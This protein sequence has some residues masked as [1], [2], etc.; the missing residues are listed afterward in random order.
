MPRFRSR[1]VFGIAST[2]AT[3][4]IA[5]GCS[6]ARADAALIGGNSKTPCVYSA[7]SIATLNAFS[8]MVGRQINCATVY[9]NASITWQQWETPWF[10]NYYNPDSDWSQWA[11]TPGTNRQLVIT[12][13]LIPSSLEG[14]DWLDAGAAGDYTTYAKTLAQNLVN[15]GLGD[16]IIRLSPEANGT[17]YSDSLGTT[18]TQWALWDQFWRQTVLAMRSVPGA[19]FQFDWCIAALYRALPLSE[20][21][22]GSDVVNIIGIDAYDTGNI[23]TTAAARW[24][25][26]LNGSDGIQAVLNFAAAQGKPISIPEWGVSPVGDSEGFGD[27]PT[28]VNGIASVVRDNPTAYQS[29][30]Y[31]YGYE[32]QLSP[33]T[34]SLAA[35]QQHFGADGDSIGTLAPGGGTTPNPLAGGGTTT[36]SDGGTTTSSAPPNV[37]T[38]S[39]Q[40]AANVSNAAV[41]GGAAKT[42]SHVTASRPRKTKPTRKTRMTTKAKAK[43]R[44]KARKRRRRR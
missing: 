3:L 7:H 10:I 9:N 31:K 36:S 20:I 13:N 14:T 30:F 42:S 16:S 32:I 17:W 1:A 33:G 11:T 4:S 12:Q 43:S 29:Y 24:N 6:A 8:L 38:G 37:A 19:N 40:V 18:P 2:L 35:Y 34:Q 25:E 26:T 23:G 44:R 39:G 28:F 22:P 41:S 27:D 15:A 21:Y 5:L